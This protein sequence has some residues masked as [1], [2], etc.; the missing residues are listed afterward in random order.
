[1]GSRLS[2][3][4]ALVTAAAN[5]IGRSTAIAFA[6]EGAR[7]IATD[8]DE[9]GLAALKDAQ[10][11][12]ETRVLDVT[13]SNHIADAAAELSPN[14]LFNCAGYVADGPILKCSPEQWEFSLRLNLTS[15][16][17]LIRAMLPDMVNGGSGS[18]INV[19][20]V[21]SSIVGVPN[22]FVYGVTKAGVIGLTKSV[23]IDY[24]HHGVR[25]NAICPGTIQTPS[26]EHRLSAFEDPQAARAQFEARQPMRR[27]G[28]AEEVAALAVYLASDE[29][30]FTTG[31]IHVIDGG[32]T[33]A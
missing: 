29:S 28:R 1:M 11:D 16:Y 18:I 4:T 5:G 33:V 8:V 3:K 10:P 13:D 7:V 26:L 25:C 24:V 20:S 23:A 2:N 21:A 15:M 22:R 6:T 27:L 14:V 17:A 9:N 30:A 19:A 32:W 12:I 31:G